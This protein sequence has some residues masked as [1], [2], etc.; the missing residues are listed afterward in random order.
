[1]NKQLLYTLLLP[2]YNDHWDVGWIDLDNTDAISNVFELQ[3]PEFDV[4]MFL[5]LSNMSTALLRTSQKTVHIASG[6][7]LIANRVSQLKA[8]K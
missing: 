2:L 8:S 1:M 5:E 4:D 6:V 3:E 7:R